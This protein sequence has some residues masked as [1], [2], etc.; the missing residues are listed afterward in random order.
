[1]Y[2]KMFQVC[3][4][5]KMQFNLSPYAFHNTEKVKI[6]TMFIIHPLPLKTSRIFAF[7]SALVNKWDSWLQIGKVW[8]NTQVDYCWLACAYYLQMFVI[9]FD[10]FFTFITRENIRMI[11]QNSFGSENPE[12]VK[13]SSSDHIQFA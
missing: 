12:M 4:M 1:M 11:I 7:S 6:N 10:Y 9:K 3:S 8:M 5:Q 13:R 2:P